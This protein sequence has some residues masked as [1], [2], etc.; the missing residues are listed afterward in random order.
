M[1]LDDDE[2][3][4]A[5]TEDEAEDTS[6][7]ADN[8]NV[9]RIEQDASPHNAL[10]TAELA[11]GLAKET[12]A[13]RL[14][15]WFDL[16][17]DR[18]VYEPTSGLGSCEQQGVPSAPAQDQPHTLRQSFGPSQDQT[19]QQDITSV[20]SVPNSLHRPSDDGDDG[21]TKDSMAELER[22]VGLALVAQAM[23]SSAS[24]PSSPRPR[25]VEALP[26]KGHS[27]DDRSE[28]TGSRPQPRD[29]SRPG[30][31]DQGLEER[32]QREAQVV[33]EPPGRRNV[34]PAVGEQQDLAEVDDTDDPKD[35]ATIKALPA[36]QLKIDKHPFRL[37]GIRAQ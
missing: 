25:S 32:E 35:K 5:D 27:Q 29:A 2:S 31:P 13:P 7:N 4:E 20:E 10:A 23:S 26:G 22:E 19:N 9:G 36:T 14:E 16:E 18:Y 6:D 33:A 15:E 1:I 12:D 34:R 3:D 30:T 28:T 24:A 11:L 37:R 21:W 17:E 8:A